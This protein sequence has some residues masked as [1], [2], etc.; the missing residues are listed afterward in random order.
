[1][2]DSLLEKLNFRPRIA[3]CRR[4]GQVRSQDTG[5]YT[6]PIRHHQGFLNAK[7][8]E[9]RKDPDYHAHLL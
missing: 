8:S 4:V 5:R 9:C 2:F 3:G 7:R 6:A 1:M